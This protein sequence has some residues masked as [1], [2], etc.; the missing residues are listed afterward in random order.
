MDAHR[1]STALQIRSYS[2]LIVLS[3][4][5]QSL[6]ADLQRGPN[7]SPKTTVSNQKRQQQIG[8]TEGDCDIPSVNFACSSRSNGRRRKS[9][10]KKVKNVRTIQS[11]VRLISSSG[12]EVIHATNSAGLY[13]FQRTIGAF[14][15]SNASK[16]L[17]HSKLTQ[18]PRNP[19]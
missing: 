5:T 12:A 10:S 1:I 8:T 14:F 7:W 17:L 16:L 3:N 13:K 9:V 18:E 6:C 2:M 19:R 4:T 11:C 15:F